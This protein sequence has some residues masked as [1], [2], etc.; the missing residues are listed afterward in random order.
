M[1]LNTKLFK[2]KT[3]TQLNS[4]YSVDS[5]ASSFSS[6]YVL[7]MVSYSSVLYTVPSG[8]IAKVTVLQFNLLVSGSQSFSNLVNSSGASYLLG[9]TGWTINDNNLVTPNNTLLTNASIYNSFNSVTSSF[10][11]SNNITNRSFIASYPATSTSSYNYYGLYNNYSKMVLPQKETS[12]QYIN[13]DTIGITYSNAGPSNSFPYY[14]NLGTLINNVFMASGDTLAMS[15]SLNTGII[16]SG[17]GVGLSGANSGG[18]YS[19]YAN[20][21]L[22]ARLQYNVNFEYSILVVEESAV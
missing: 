15:I 11:G 5:F 6:S 9:T 22:S 3:S 12:L 18:A 19:Y 20:P 10:S 21:Y 4:S 17:I 14:A 2:Y 13:F 16:F 7:P 1:A 8:R